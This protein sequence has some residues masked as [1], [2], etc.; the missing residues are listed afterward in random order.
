V[1]EFNLWQQEVGIPRLL[2]SPGYVSAVR[3]TAVVGEPRYTTIFEVNPSAAVKHPIDQESTF[4]PDSDEL[5]KHVRLD[6]AVYQ[7]IFPETGVV[8]GVDWHEEGTPGAILFNRFNVD[9]ERDEEFNAW[10]NTEH[11][12]LLATVPG[13]I[14]DRRF[15]AVKGKQKY[16]ARYDL[17]NPDVPTTEAWLKIRYT[18]WTMRVG[19]SVKDSW[20]NVLVPIG[21]IQ[22]AK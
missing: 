18:P 19:R 14:S 15:A 3:C 5:S 11:L 21:E 13:T 12:P 16:L 17:A 2:E 4:A 1:A 8:E 7:Q 9:P 10:Y 6:V 20:R 22:I